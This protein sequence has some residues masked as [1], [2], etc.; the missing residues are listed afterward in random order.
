MAKMED[1]VRSLRAKMASLMSRMVAMFVD[2]SLRANFF[3]LWRTFVEIG[4]VGISRVV[5][6]TLVLYLEIN[7]QY[8]YATVESYLSVRRHHLKID[9]RAVF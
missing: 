6:S 4:F 7:L 3:A 1:P 5:D 9:G 8:D 2:A